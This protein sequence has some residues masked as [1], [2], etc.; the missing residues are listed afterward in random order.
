MVHPYEALR[1]QS[2][3]H[4]AHLLIWKSVFIVDGHERTE[5]REAHGERHPHVLETVDFARFHNTQVGEIRSILNLIIQ[6]QQASRDSFQQRLDRAYSI[7]GLRPVEVTR[8]LA[9]LRIVRGLELTLG[10][11]VQGS[12]RVAERSDSASAS[13]RLDSSQIGR[14]STSLQ[15]FVRRLGWF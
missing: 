8:V 11:C 12:P 9:V 13:G 2:G 7:Y 10:S 6:G 4:L 1:F 14:S 5:T 15:S 3:P